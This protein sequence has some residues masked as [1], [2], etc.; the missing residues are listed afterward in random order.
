MPI[1]TVT[2]DTTKD[3]IEW[4]SKDFLLYFSGR[5]KTTSGQS[6]NIPPEAWVAMMSRI[7][8][9]KS[10]LK[11]D[12]SDYKQ[13]IDTVFDKLFTQ[14]GF[15][16]SFGAIVSEKVYHISKKLPV[17]KKTHLTT[18]SEFEQLQKELYSNN[19]LFQ[20]FN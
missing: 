9:F 1:L 6:F 8:S 20:K 4:N 12:N 16:P 19:L 10:K 11:L 15:V 14:K 2:P 3:I 7:K 13:F 5:Y 18:G 17:L